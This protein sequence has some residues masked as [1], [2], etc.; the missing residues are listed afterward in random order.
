M[1]IKVIGNEKFITHINFLLQLDR[2]LQRTKMFNNQSEIAHLQA[3]VISFLLKLQNVTIWKAS[4]KQPFEYIS[5]HI[6]WF[7]FVFVE[8]LQRNL[9]SC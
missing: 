2:C 7:E 6:D 1:D 5:G 9:W 8:Y 4:T 3:K